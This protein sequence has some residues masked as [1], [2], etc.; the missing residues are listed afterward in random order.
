MYGYS[1]VPRRE[2]VP[3]E[4]QPLDDELL[5][6]HAETRCLALTVADPVVQRRLGEIADDVLEMTCR[7]ARIWLDQTAASGKQETTCL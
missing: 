4:G 7:D 2:A 6:L 5:A 3:L 1:S